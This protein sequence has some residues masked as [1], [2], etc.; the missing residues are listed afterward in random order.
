[1]KCTRTT[2]ARIHKVR[3]RLLGGKRAMGWDFQARG[4]RIR[5]PDPHRIRLGNPDAT[6]TG[7]AG[8][9]PFGVFLRRL[10]IER[11]LH[12]FDDLKPGR[13]VVYPM[14]AQLR[15]LLDAAAVGES[16]VFGIESLGADPLFVHLAGGSVPSIDT[17]YRD[18]CRFDDLAL[19]KLELVMANQGLEEVRRLRGSRVHLDI[20]TTVEVLFGHQEGALP[21][22]NPRYHGR[23]SYHPLLAV[24]AEAGTCVGATLRPGDCGLGGEDAPPIRRYVERVRAAVGPDG[25]VVVRIDAGGDCAEFFDA[26]SSAG[27]H[28]LVKAKL[29]RDLVGAVAH[30]TKWTTVEEDADGRPLRQV[31]EIDFARGSWKE[32][33]IRVRVIAVRSRDRDVGKQVFLWED[34]DY[35]THVVLTNDFNRSADDIAR[36]YD[37]RAEIEPMIAEFKQALGIGKVPSQIFNAN[38]TAFLLK[39]LAHN[40]LRRYARHIQAPPTWRLPWIRRAFFLVPGRLVR[41]GRQWT[42]RLPP[43]SALLLQAARLE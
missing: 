30:H 43:R 22:P 3:R 2:L 10:G 9:A 32:R 42:L 12:T 38:H 13:Q 39:L 24:V 33:G 28:F 29:T 36:D 23:P 34:L 7:M 17:V 35:T 27:A 6:L 41:S 8:L 25:D 40:L 4:R 11:A 15:L 21:G 19:A 26:I 5:R 1:M 20:D 16:R 31:A 37:G 18:L 14:G